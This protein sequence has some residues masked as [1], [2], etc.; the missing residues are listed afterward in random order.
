MNTRIHFDPFAADATAES[1][2]AEQLELE[3]QADMAK[4]IRITMDAFQEAVDGKAKGSRSGSLTGPD[5]LY[6]ASDVEEAREALR[7]IG[8]N[9]C[10]ITRD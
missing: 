5:G 3:A 7:R 4:A 10:D 6:K 1:A 2:Q 8:K 9:P